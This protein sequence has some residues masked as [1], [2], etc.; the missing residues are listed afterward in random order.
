MQRE[1]QER[2][3]TKEPAMSTNWRYTSLILQ[4]SSG[5]HAS[6]ELR[7]HVLGF[8]TVFLPFDA[9]EWNADVDK[10]LKILR[11][12][13]PDFMVLGSSLYLFKHPISEIS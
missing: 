6:H 13:K 3:T 12:E 11:E 5:V 9:E 4:I 2:G 8:K 7:A 10:A 1:S